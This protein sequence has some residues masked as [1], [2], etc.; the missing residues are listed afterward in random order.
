MND[1]HKAAPL[2]HL[3]AL[4]VAAM[5]CLIGDLKTLTKSRARALLEQLIT[6][7]L[8][9]ARQTTDTTR[10][11][12]YGITSAALPTTTAPDDLLRAWAIAARDRLE[13]GAI[14]V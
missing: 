3:R 2:D 9:M 1:L 14:H 13:L 5:I 10:L 11:A 4:Q 6:S 7:G 12:I 8:G